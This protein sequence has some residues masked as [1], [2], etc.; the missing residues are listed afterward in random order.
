MEISAAFATTIALFLHT[1]KFRKMIGPRTSF[2]IY[3]FSY[4]ST[5]ISYYFIM[6]IFAAN[7]DLCLIAFGGL[8]IN[9]K[10]RNWQTAYQVLVFGLLVG[11]R[12]D[13]LPEAIKNVLPLPVGI[14]SF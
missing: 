10:S 1:L 4:M 5:F 7:A 13:V 2:M 12:F 11:A 9:F 3:F 14:G 6:D 8:L